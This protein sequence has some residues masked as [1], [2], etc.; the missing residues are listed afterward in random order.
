MLPNK[1][2]ELEGK[3]Y[4]ILTRNRHADLYGDLVRPTI[5]PPIPRKSQIDRDYETWRACRDY[6]CYSPKSSPLRKVT[7]VGFSPPRILTRSNS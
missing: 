4:T 2:Q 6:D 7:Q 1:G 5:F 3:Q